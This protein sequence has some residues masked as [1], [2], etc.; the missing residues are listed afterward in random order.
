MIRIDFDDVLAQLSSWIGHT[1]WYRGVKPSTVTCC[2]SSI[3]LA[4]HTQAATAVHILDIDGTLYSVPLTYQVHPSN[5]DGLIGHAIGHDAYGQEVTIDI[6]DAT[7]HID[8][9]TDLYEIF[10]ENR[11]T[12][13]TPW[14]QIEHAGLP[15]AL[16]TVP[17]RD[18]STLGHPLSADKLTSEQS[19]TSIIYRFGHHDEHQPAGIMCKLFRVISSGHNPDVELQQALDTAG[20]PSVPRQYGSVVGSWDNTG[21]Y[22]LVVAKSFL[23]DQLML[24]RFSCMS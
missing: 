10:Q 1:R 22:D 13:I 2:A 20:S 23:L 21:S 3:L 5:K 7:D 11:N 19:N 9:K 18:M 15:L 16:Q 14:L 24:G 6:F 17:A 4:V 8:G 12:E